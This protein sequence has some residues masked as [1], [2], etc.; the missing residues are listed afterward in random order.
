MNKERVAKLEGQVNSL[1]N[2]LIRAY[3]KFL[4][5]RPMMVNDQLNQRISSQERGVCFKQLRNWLY[6]DFIL[7]LVKRQVNRAQRTAKNRRGL[8]IF[9][10]IKVLYLKIGEERKLLEKARTIIDDLNLLVRNADAGWESFSSWR[11]RMF[12]NTRR[13]QPSSDGSNHSAPTLS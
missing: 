6:W 10:D 4:F 7:E 8:Y 12:A 3:A 11:L 5:L 13:F 9:F 1:L 2:L